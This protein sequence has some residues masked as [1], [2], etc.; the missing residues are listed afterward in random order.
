MRIFILSECN[1]EMVTDI[2]KMEELFGMFLFFLFMCMTL[3]FCDYE[4][5]V[6]MKLIL[7]FCS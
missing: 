7:Y 5:K 3:L 6:G 4:K 1:E 2:F